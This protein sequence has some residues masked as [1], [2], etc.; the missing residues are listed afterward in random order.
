MLRVV[1]TMNNSI[2]ASELVQ[3]S[4]NVTSWINEILD[5]VWENQVSSWRYLPS[6]KLIFQAI[7]NRME[8]CSM[9]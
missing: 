1:Q 6:Q 3:Q 4:K 5:G 2:Y 8:I 7:S 9:F